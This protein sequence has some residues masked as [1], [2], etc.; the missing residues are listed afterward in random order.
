MSESRLFLITE[1]KIERLNI[2][3]KKNGENIQTINNI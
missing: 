3:T 2:F 1:A